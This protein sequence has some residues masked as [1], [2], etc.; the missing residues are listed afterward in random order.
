MKT[1]NDIICPNCRTNKI[2]KQ[3]NKLLICTKCKEVYPVLNGVPVMLTKKNDF[4]HLKKALLP[5]KYRV[6]KYGS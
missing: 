1:K 3:N 6:E 4:F 2:L 5:A